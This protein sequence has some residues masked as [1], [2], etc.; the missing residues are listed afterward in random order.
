MKFGAIP[1]GP[2]T[3]NLARGLKVAPHPLRRREQSHFDKL[4]AMDMPHIETLEQA[5]HF[6]YGNFT[7]FF[8]NHLYWFL[9]CV[10]LGVFQYEIILQIRNIYIILC[11]IHIWMGFKY[12]NMLRVCI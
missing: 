12:C 6:V 5:K 11:S 4:Y 2:V 8:D 9:T 7:F 3:G 1:T 10:G